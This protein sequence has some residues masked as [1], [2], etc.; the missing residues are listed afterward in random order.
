MLQVPMRGGPNESTKAIILV[1]YPMV[2]QL[3]LYTN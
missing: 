1:S 3:V 2:T